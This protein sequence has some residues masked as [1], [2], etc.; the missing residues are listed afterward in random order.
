MLPPRLNRRFVCAMA[1]ILVMSFWSLRAP[2]QTEPPAQQPAAAQFRHFD[3]DFAGGSL[4]QYI[5]AVRKAHGAANIVLVGDYKDIAVPAV[6]LRHVTL[7]AA[8]RLIG[9]SIESV[10][11]N[12]YVKVEP[13]MIEGSSDRAYR[14]SAMTH[15]RSS[16]ATSAVWSVAENINAGFKID[17]L[18]GAVQ[19]ALSTFPTKA[20]IRFHEPTS[21]LIVR[22][23]KEQIALTSE[24]LGQLKGDALRQVDMLE[25]LRN[26]IRSLEAFREKAEIE[27]RIAAKRHEVAKKTLELEEKGLI[28]LGIETERDQ[29]RRLAPLEL[30]VIET[31]A[32]LR[33]AQTELDGYVAQLRDLHAQLEAGAAQ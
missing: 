4:E 16:A 17:D 9:G 19:V 26:R 6:T 24:T 28:E 3:L 2:A 29:H 10:D 1:P 27:V 21:L 20:T 30:E 11:R 22:G 14:V 23:T 33:M 8:T 7:D 15:D 18:L 5:S 12:E 32:K 25:S 31:E 13:V